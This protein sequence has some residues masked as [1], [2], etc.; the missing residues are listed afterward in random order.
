MEDAIAIE[1]AVKAIKPE[2]IKSCCW[3]LCPDAV[4]AFTG[5]VIV[6]GIVK[7]IVDMAKKMEREGFQ[8]RDFREIQ[9]LIEATPEE[10]TEDDVNESFQTSAR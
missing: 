1:K 8:D 9:E 5:F 6:K 3:K 4:W 10:L 2:T 7:E